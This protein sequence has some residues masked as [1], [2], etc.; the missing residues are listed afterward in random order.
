MG[1]V[2]VSVDGPPTARDRVKPAVSQTEDGLWLVEYAPLAAGP[3][4]VNVYFSGQP[5][6]NS[7]FTTHAKPG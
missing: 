5:I 4:H 6:N 3:H 7:P 1:A 2:E